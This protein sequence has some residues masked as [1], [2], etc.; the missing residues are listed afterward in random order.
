MKTIPH[1]ITLGLLGGCVTSV[2]PTYSDEDIIFDP[3]LLGAWTN[4]DSSEIY[5]VS[6]VESRAYS[7]VIID[8]DCERSTLEM[9]L[10]QIGGSKFV[11][12]SY[13]DRDPDVVSLQTHVMS[14]FEQVGSAVRLRSMDP[15]W[16][17]EYLEE[18]PQAIEHLTT[19]DDEIVITART[20]DLQAFQREHEEATDAWNETV[21]TRLTDEAAEGLAAHFFLYRCSW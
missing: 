10:A 9:H 8:E 11:D 15:R 18:N 5:L 6:Q 19:G 1:L 14:R 2:Y 16:L 7:V 12:I 17:R 13:A 21:L 3:A 4:E 20:P